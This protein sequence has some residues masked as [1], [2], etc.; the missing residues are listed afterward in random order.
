VDDSALIQALHRMESRDLISAEWG[1]TEKERR[2]R[3]YKCTAAG[4]AH[5]RA[6]GAELA[7]DVAA[8]GAI[9]AAKPSR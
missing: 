3:Y 5:L 7:S 4:R 9:L 6:E 1:V 8:I 2:A